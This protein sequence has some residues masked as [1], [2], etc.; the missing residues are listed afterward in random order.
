MS[1]PNSSF[2]KDASESLNLLSEPV[3]GP[4]GAVSGLKMGD[5]SAPSN[6]VT[7]N[8]SVE[9]RTPFVQ[10]SPNGSSPS[11]KTEPDENT[12][13]TATLVYWIF[14]LHGIGT[15]MPWNM[16]LTIA[17][18]Y[19]IGYKFHPLKNGT[20]PPNYSQNF[21]SYLGVFSQLPNLILNCL[22]LFIV[23]KAD[24][25]VRIIYSLVVVASICLTTVV[26]VFIPTHEW[27]FGFFIFTMITV[28]ILNSANGVYQNS[29]YGILA[30]FPA[31]FTNAVVIGNNTC[32]IFVT[33]ILMITLS[34]TD[35]TLLVAFSY[36]LVALLTVLLCLGTFFYLPKLPF[37]EFYVSKA[38]Q[39]RSETTEQKLN[40]DDFKFVLK[41]AWVQM[42][43][44]FLTFFVTLALFPAVVA[45]TGLYPNNRKYDVFIPQ[46]LYTQVIIFLNFNVF[47]TVGNVIANYVQIPGHK[48][49]IWFTALRLL[50]LPFFWFCNYGGAKRLFPVYIENEWVFIGGVTLMSLTHGYF[51]SL[52]M[53]YAPR[54]VPNSAARTAGM[55]SAFFLVLG[56]AVGV[57]FTFIEARIFVAQ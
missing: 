57:A 19:F 17:P 2:S 51:S 22:N 6:D 4:Y 31:K 18:D 33:V 12:S 56:I 30:D 40:L 42:L 36:F 55:M 48:N 46:Y 53:M 35:N 9:E 26:F 44:V 28:V 52:S 37:Y 49:L 38:K 32:G 16:F 3:F 54:A 27:M 11:S 47:A 15:L 5:S 25:N 7:L 45:S 50:F 1:D 13:R 21:F 24:L 34:V 39:S 8:V 43:S 10:A 14:V 41:H 29:I 20:E 23:L